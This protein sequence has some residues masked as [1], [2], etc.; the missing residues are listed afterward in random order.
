MRKPETR[1]LKI[2][3]FPNCQD[4]LP[5]NE[6]FGICGPFLGYARLLTKFHVPLR[7]ND[8]H[9]LV[10]VWEASIYRGCRE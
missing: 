7:Q 6:P 2:N 10:P 8:K 4:Q 5:N 1:I 3:N 9:R